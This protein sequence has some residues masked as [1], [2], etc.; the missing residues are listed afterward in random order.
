MLSVTAYTVN[1]GNGGADYTVSLHTATGTI[2]PAA[3]GITAV[4]DSRVYDG[5]TASSKTPSVGTLYSADTVTG[6]TQ[7]FASRHVLG[8]AGSTLTVTGYTVNDG[9]GGA[10]Y[11]VT[12]PT[13][14]GTISPAA[15]D[16]RAVSDSRGYDGT[17]ASS[18]TPS[19]G[20]LYSAD[21][22]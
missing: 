21:T 22:V 12:T 17:T 6:R 2:S 4:S 19:V 10:D 18:T 8:V 16:V 9:N 3:L 13:A 20:T 1:D 15:L 7:A 11:T 14:T 5:T